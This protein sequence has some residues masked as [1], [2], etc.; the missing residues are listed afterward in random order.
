[1]AEGQVL[2]DHKQVK[3][4]ADARRAQ[5]ACVKGTGQRRG[6]RDVGMIRLDFPGFSGKE[7]LQAISWDD[8]FRQ[9]DE[10]NLALLVQERTS[11][12]TKSNFSK[13]IRRDD[14]RAGA[15]KKT[16]GRRSAR[17]ANAGAGQKR[18]RS[19][20]TTSTRSAGNRRR[21]QSSRSRSSARKT[22]ARKTSSRKRASAR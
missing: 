3:Q 9:F 15:G 16:S 1:M 8:W 11:G 21:A 17:G 20:R 22:S 19:R 12:G 4:W 18:T 14:A 5:P 10:N 2:T 6:R 7:S 13:L